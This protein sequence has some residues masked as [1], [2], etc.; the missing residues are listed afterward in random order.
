M[1]RN[2]LPFFLSYFHICIL[3]DLKVQVAIKK[4][5]WLLSFYGVSESVVCIC[6]AFNHHSPPPTVRE[7][8]FWS[9]PGCASRSAWL[10][11]HIEPFSR[12]VVQQH[13]DKC[14]ALWKKDAQNLL[15]RFPFFF[16]FKS[17][18]S[19]FRINFILKE[20]KHQSRILYAN[21]GLWRTTSI[22]NYLVA[23]VIKSVRSSDDVT[24]N[25]HQ[26]QGHP[27]DGMPSNLQL[28]EQINNN[29][30]ILCWGHRMPL[31]LRD[32]TLTCFVFSFTCNR[33]NFERGK[34]K[35]LIYGNGM[36]LCLLG[37][38]T[39]RATVVNCVGSQFLSYS[40]D[41]V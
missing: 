10:T 26:V 32:D 29:G 35:I 18:D 41:D 31:K 27:V 40:K 13:P 9:A 11:R 28:T 8:T 34:K 38:G 16:S 19:I 17:R 3:Y 2:H 6:V 15:E 22:A 25:T 30:G 4:Y 23:N 14:R 33:G 24:H 20:E 21:R 36:N 7:T 39:L 1:L 12:R 5:V 37:G